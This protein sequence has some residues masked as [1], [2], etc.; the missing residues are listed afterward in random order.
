MPQTTT[1]LTGLATL[2]SKGLRRIETWIEIS[3][4]RR[5]LAT[6]DDRMLKDIGISRAS[7]NF[8]A[9]R[10]FW[11]IPQEENRERNGAKCTDQSSELKPCYPPDA[12]C[13]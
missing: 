10:P 13:A 1:L 8:E 11:D 4:Q 7:A 6:L 9:S 3:R 5:T 2:A 12:A